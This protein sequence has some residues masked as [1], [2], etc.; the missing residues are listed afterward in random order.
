MASTP[1]KKRVIVDDRNVTTEILALFSDRF[2]YGYETDD[3][4]KFK[5]AKGELVR[6]VPFETA[7]TKYLVKVSVEMD[8]KID[9]FLEDDD[10]EEL[11]PE[12][13]GGVPEEDLAD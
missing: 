2:P 3:I 7:D 1:E 5:N 9:A 11:P 6:A 4:I 10:S 8:A 13:E 12:A